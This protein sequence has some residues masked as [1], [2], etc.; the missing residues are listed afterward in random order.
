MISKHQNRPRFT[1]K[2]GGFSLNHMLNLIPKYDG[3]LT[4]FN[5]RVSE[6]DVM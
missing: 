4:G 3:G 5:F 1:H 2:H 6:P